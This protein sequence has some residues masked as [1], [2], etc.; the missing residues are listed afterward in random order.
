MR[1]RLKALREGWGDVDDLVGQDRSLPTTF[2][3]TSLVV[4]MKLL[5]AGMGFHQGR[6]MV[7]PLG[8][9]SL[10]DSD[11]RMVQWGGAESL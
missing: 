9:R 10:S 5:T 6:K 7:L 3:T 8:C 2:V 1:R 11:A 4:L